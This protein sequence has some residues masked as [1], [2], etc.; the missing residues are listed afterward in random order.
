MTSLWLADA[1]TID[2]DPFEPGAE[3]DEVIVGAGITGL[4]TALLFARAGRRVAVVEA[5]FIGAVTTG[6]TTA[7]LT[8]LQGT[9]LSKI[10]AAMYP[11]VVRAYADGNRAAFD[12]MIDY[13]DSRG[14]PYDRRDAI[15]Y[16]ATAEGVDAVRREYD[17]ARS[18]GLDVDL[19]D[20]AG[21]P[22]STRAAVTLA[23][24]AQFDPMV[25]L[26]ALAADVRALGGRVFEGAGVTGVRA[27]APARVRTSLGDV[28]GERVILAT[29]TPILDRGLY[30]AKVSA[31][32]SYAQSFRV[33]GGELPRGMFIGVET[34]TRSIRTHGDL[35]LVGGNG[36]HVGRHPSPARA[37][38]ELTDWT[39]EHWPGAERTHSWAAQDYTTPHHVP[40]VGYLPRGRR[41]ILLATG[42]DKWGM[43]N[44]VATAMTLAAD[45]L[46]GHS[47]W[48]RT[49]RHRITMPRAVASGIGENLAVG[50][51]YA[52]GYGR[53]LTRR[54]P[55]APP[56]EGEG[57]TGRLGVRP[58]GVS[59]VDGATCTVST[60]C[61]HMFAALSWNDGEKSWDCPAHGSRFAADGTRLEGPAKRDLTRL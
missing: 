52:K 40:F 61:T 38:Q 46:G 14:I 11:A 17:L 29:G 5:R 28:L 31:Q 60:I 36:H 22:F 55:D 45:V 16:A 3:F 19:V 44:S 23:A 30:F 51:W 26:A 54:L 7:K 37:I 39:T 43:T 15:T 32:R 13:L 1:P 20:D 25:V 59:T 27:S 42:F 2:T 58:A 48:Q 8:Q 34:P 12:W 35:L 53:A 21:L 57:T 6:N 4:V 49:L 41:R 24:Q 47:A 33:A 56:A 50:W 18:V 9:Q 10:R